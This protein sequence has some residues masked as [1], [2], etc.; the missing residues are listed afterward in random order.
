MQR[1]RSP[2]VIAALVGVAALLGLLAYG[3]SHTT[4]DRGLED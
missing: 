3:L 4:P 2:F 1:L